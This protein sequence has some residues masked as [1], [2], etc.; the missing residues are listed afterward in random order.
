MLEQGAKMELSDDEFDEL[1][2]FLDDDS[3]GTITLDELQRIVDLAKKDVED[4]CMSTR[5]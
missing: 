3:S 4:R 5:G 1:W 2:Q